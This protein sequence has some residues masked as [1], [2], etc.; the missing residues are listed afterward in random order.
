MKLYIARFS[1]F[2]DNKI[3][4]VKQPNQTCH[5]KSKPSIL[6]VICIIQPMSVTT[7]KIIHGKK[8]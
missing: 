4:T 8:T 2:Q 1:V 6:N 3:L 5:Q 7:L